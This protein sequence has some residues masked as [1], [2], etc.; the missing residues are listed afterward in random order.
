VRV[1][2]CC[3]CSQ[4]AGDP[5]NDLIATLLGD[6][7]YR[8]RVIR[9]Y[10]HLAVIPSLG[11]LVDGHVLLCTTTHVPGFAALPVGL[12][13]A[14]RRAQDDLTAFLSHE[15]RRSVHA[16]EHG[17]SMTGDHVPCTVDHA[18]LHLLPLP[19]EVVVELPPS[20]EWQPI[21]PSPGALARATGGR[22]YIRY[23]A[24]TGE[25][26]VA[27]A[28][29]GPFPSQLMRRVFAGALGLGSW[30][31]RDDPAPD[32]ADATWARLAVLQ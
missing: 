8:R 23:E 10:E 27:V 5:S 29:D 12:Y 32:A 3:L 15:Y 11:P 17:S 25:C 13:H 21:D 14:Y 6:R 9:E 31:W 18:H 26:A 16:F 28:T 24:P 2:E 20:L 30:N 19:G 1:G 4:V 22:E 7:T